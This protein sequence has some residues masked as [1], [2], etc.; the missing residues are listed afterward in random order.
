[1]K[2]AK[3]ICALVLLL[4]AVLQAQAKAAGDEESGWS[5]AQRFQGSS[6]SSGV[7]LKTNS[8]LFYRFSEHIE[9][10]GG[11]PVYFARQ[12]T[13]SSTTSPGFIN[14]IG[15]VFTGLAV[16]TSSPMLSFSSD[17]IATAPTG[18]RDRGFS[19]GHATVDWTN[20]L[21]RSFENITPFASV[22][23]ANTV[24]DTA[25]FVRPFSSKGAVAH[26]E[27][28]ALIDL[29]PRTS[30][31]GSAYAVRASG[32]QQ[33]VSKVISRKP[34]VST[35]SATGGRPTAVGRQARGVFETQTD[36]TG[37]AAIA[38]DHGFSTWLTLRPS[39][40]SDIQIGYSRSVVYQLDSLFFGI[41]IRVGR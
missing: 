3:W 26:F 19:T 27:G 5:F 8:T 40:T 13:S 31:G 41:G 36:V 38:N 24:S 16:S 9:M 23:L 22:G 2:R 17:L 28:G 14:G 15:N 20:T 34:P 30:I 35:T 7:I 37:S 21:S 18:D 32:D 1:M 25:F 4:P 6:N 11:V 39:A 12:S 33:I 29:M 10:Y